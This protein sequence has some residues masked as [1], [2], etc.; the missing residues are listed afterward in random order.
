MVLIVMEAERNKLLES[1]SHINKRAQML[2][3]IVPVYNVADYVVECLES[4]SSQTFQ[5]FEVIVVDDGSTD[6]SGFL[7]DMFAKHDKRFFVIHQ[8]NLG[9]SAARNA[10]LNRARGDYI[11]FVDPDDI[12][13]PEMYGRLLEIC[14]GAE[15][16]MANCRSISFRTADYTTMQV[17]QECH[18]SDDASIR[19]LDEH[20]FW[21]SAVDLQP[22]IGVAVWHKVFRRKLF[23]GIHFCEGMVFEDLEV[24]PKI[25]DGVRRIAA[26]N[27]T[28][29]A[30]RLRSGS[31]MSANAANNWR[32]GCQAYCQLIEFAMSKRWA[33]VACGAVGRLMSCVARFGMSLDSEDFQIREEHDRYRA[34]AIRY[35]HEISPR[36]W[37]QG[38]FIVRA[39]PFL[40]SE[41]LCVVIADYRKK[42][43]NPRL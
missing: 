25:L 29:Y 8:Q 12:L 32:D 14:E 40:V 22:T 13:H 1:S 34:L 2:S 28:L 39:L 10:G 31:I 35:M 26:T 27:E 19:I 18:R 23:D 7:C 30:Y 38:S 17:V 15:A 24:M 3:I 4:I 20:E 9:L 21:K 5:D 33:D 36:C 6:E 42:V 41:R 43:L 16:M 11:G 37:S